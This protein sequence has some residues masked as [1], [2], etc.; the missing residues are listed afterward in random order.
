MVEPVKAW[1]KRHGWPLFLTVVGL[2]LLVQLLTSWRRFMDQQAQVRDVFDR[3]IAS[4]ELNIPTDLLVR[5]P[6]S[7]ILTALLA[8]AMLGM[9]IG[10]S[11]GKRA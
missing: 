9:A 1:L 8:G 2:G 6:G 5:S 10:V 11:A 4:A 3:V 7:L